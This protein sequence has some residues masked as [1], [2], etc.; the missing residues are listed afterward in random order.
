MPTM[1]FRERI[2]RRL[3]G[4]VVGRMGGAVVPGASRP[5]GAARVMLY[6]ASNVGM[7]HLM[8]L[9]R[10]AAALRYRLGR[11]DML[12]CTDASQCPEPFATGA[13]VVRLPG[14][15]FRDEDYGERPRDMAIE[16]AQLTRLRASI[17]L[18]SAASFAPDLLL[19]DTNPHGKRNEL[20][21]ALRFLKRS[22][23]HT[24]TVLQLRDIPFPPDEPF[25]LKPDNW[26]FERDLALYDAVHVAGAQAFFDLEKAYDWPPNLGGKLRYV[27]FVLPG[28]EEAEA[29]LEAD[30]EL[31]RMLDAAHTRRIVVSFGGGWAAD[32]LG[33]AVLEAYESLSATENSLQMFVFTGPALSAEGLQALRARVA[34][35]P[36]L[37][38]RRFSPAFSEVLRRADVAVLQAG[39]TPFQ[40]LDSDI[41]MLVYARDFSTREQQERAER[42]GRFEG[43]RT[44]D[45]EWLRTR[46]LA[47]ALRDMLAAPRQA[48]RTG[49]AF[50]GATRSAEALAQMIEQT[51]PTSVRTM[52]G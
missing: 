23:A 17:L 25:R 26:R 43:V 16:N 45:A 24:R 11:V 52:R 36:G 21:P 22:G 28:A 14:F 19:M 7:G 9:G 37:A 12:L 48:R 31:S 33:K 15:A 34:S 39:S 27:G 46:D 38:M 44:I 50:D 42:L 1:S 10:V 40:I 6:C 5:Q 20:E 18:A 51:R 35:M 29:A 49:L 13:G 41:P 32:S 47:S 8:R 3:V 4:P 30:A 2:L